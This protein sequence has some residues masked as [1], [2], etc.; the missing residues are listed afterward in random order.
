MGSEGEEQL[1][2]V[3]LCIKGVE[4]CSFYCCSGNM[5]GAHQH[6]KFQKKFQKKF[7]VN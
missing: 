3:L 7:A 1:Q 5:R 4:H 6:W 2:N